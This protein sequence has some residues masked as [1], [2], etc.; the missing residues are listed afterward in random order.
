M[1]FLYEIRNAGAEDAYLEIT[2]YEGN[3]SYLDIPAEI[4]GIPVRCIGSHSFEKREELRKVSLPG[5]INT[6][7]SF[8]F[9]SSANLETIRMYG[10]VKDYYDGVIR[11]CSALSEIYLILHGNDFSVMKS[12]LDDNDRTLHFTLELPDGKV[13]LTFPS[14][15]YGFQENTFART[16][17]FKYEGTGYTYR[18]Y[19]YKDHI[20]YKW[21]DR[22]FP[23]AAHADPDAA[24]DICLDRLQY[25][26]ELRS[27]F[28]SQYE[29]FLS[30]K[31][32]DILNV[33]ISR[34]DVER[35]RFVTEY[36]GLSGQRIFEREQIDEAV[37]F[38]SARDEAEICAVLME[39][40]R[41]H[42]GSDKKAEMFSLDDW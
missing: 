6:I 13:K 20:D 28:Q 1:P 24:V 18:S 21:Y 7:R 14:Y 37:R 23:Q 5:T 39:Y 38:A 30:K 41:R 19:V 3:A 25:P 36:E 35:I 4:D 32:S 8:A 2:G 40:Q 42:F 29:E 11:R 16:I 12:M 33:L 31:G 27:E 34:R 26:Y 9:Y 17:Q 10:D 15:E 22:L